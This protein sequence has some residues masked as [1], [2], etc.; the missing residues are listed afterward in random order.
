M[1][2]AKWLLWALSYAACNN[3]QQ[4]VKQP[5]LPTP[6]APQL[7]S[8]FS[9][10]LW[11]NNARQCELLM[12]PHPSHLLVTHWGQAANLHLLDALLVQSTV[13]SQS[14]PPLT[15]C[16]IWHSLSMAPPCHFSPLASWTPC[17]PAFPS[18]SLAVFSKDLG[19]LLCS[20]MIF[21]RCGVPTQFSALSWSCPVLRLRISLILY[22]R[23]S[24][25]LWSQVCLLLHPPH[26]IESY[27]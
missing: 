19:W 9:A 14:S 12:C 6:Y 22:W 23:L 4:K 7:Q 13:G 5:S 26:H 18:R 21:L 2:F 8:H 1:K 20:A 16:S 17:S 3:F 15:P 10:H 11:N 27:I 24:L 25:Y